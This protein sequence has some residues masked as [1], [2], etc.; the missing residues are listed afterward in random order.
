MNE[1]IIITVSRKVEFTK[2]I[3]LSFQLKADIE[4][5]DIMQL[6]SILCNTIKTVNELYPKGD[7]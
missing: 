4:K 2:S 5:V 7:W 6:D 1:N 3:T